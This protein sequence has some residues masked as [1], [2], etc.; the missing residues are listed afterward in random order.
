MTRP[1]KT[2]EGKTGEGKLDADRPKPALTD[3]A[4]LAGEWVQVVG[5]ATAGL[6][7]AEVAALAA[8]LVPQVELTPGAKA[9]KT[10]ADEA[11]AEDG[12][13]NMPL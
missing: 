11:A 6:V 9:A 8:V 2:G 7:A 5:A 13:D 4:A 10:L 12:I 1:D 3:L